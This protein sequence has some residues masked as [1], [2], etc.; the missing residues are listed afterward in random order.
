MMF[1]PR[2]KKNRIDL[3]DYDYRRDLENRQLLSQLSGFDIEVLNEIV[4][5]SLKFPLQ[6]IAETLDVTEECLQSSIDK[7]SMSGLFCV[8]E[9]T[10][11]VDKEM[12]KYYELHTEKFDEDFRPDI[13]YLQEL[14]SHIPIHVLPNW[15]AIP[16]SSNNIFDSILE[17]YMRTP[18]VYE[19]YLKDLEFDNPL[20]NEII[21]LLYKSSELILSVEE[22]S[23]QFN[24]PNNELSEI[25][26]FLEYHFVCFVSYRKNGSEWEEV[27]TPPHEWTVFLQKVNQLKP[28]EIDQVEKIRRCHQHD[29]GFVQDLTLL[30]R[31][32]SE[33]PLSIA[34]IDDIKEFLPDIE[35]NP[36]PD[37][38]LECL[39]DIL[40][41]F[42]ICKIDDNQLF[43][44]SASQDWVQKSIQEQALTIYR[45]NKIEGKSSEAYVDKNMREIEKNLRKVMDSGWI[46]FPDFVNCMTAAIGDAQPTTLTRK[47]RKWEYALPKYSDQDKEL[48]FNI[49][50]QLF[51]AGMLAT[52]IHEGEY[53]FCVT[54]FGRMTLG[55]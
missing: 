53:C 1:S 37:L 54:P 43:P 45:F 15:Y 14:L 6:S 9:G 41:T 46:K 11:H 18:K 36:E 27:I 25:L 24:L 51:Q 7:L 49:M 13:E 31:H 3:L 17:Q 5:N 35:S 22:I 38:Y 16:R 30:T 29:F 55:E 40:E 47:G 39:R 8:I 4:F 23:K 34:T 50:K 20:L 32:M 52:G 44:G 33:K 10:V 2:S 42:Q 48:A 21:Q 19:R 26:L 28:I 12:R